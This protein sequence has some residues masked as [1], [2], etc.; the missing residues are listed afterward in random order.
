MKIIHLITAFQLGGAEKVAFDIVNKLNKDYEIEL[1]AIFKNDDDFSKEFKKNL[2]KNKI[3]WRELALTTKNSKF[4]YL[5]LFYSSLALLFYMPKNKIKIIHSHTDLPDFVLAIMLNF[6]K[7]IKNKKLN[8]LRTIHNTELWPTHFTIGKF[9]ESSFEND[10][11]VFI[12]KDVEKAYRL[13][14]KKYNLQE[15]PNT[16]FISNGVDFEKYNDEVNAE[17]LKTLNITLDKNKINLLFV[18]RLVEQKGFDL[19]IDLFNLLDEKD[20]N[21]F[22]IYAFGSGELEKLVTEKMPIDIYKPITNIHEIYKCFDYL[23][24]PSRFE[25]LGL[26]SLEASASRLPVIASYSCGLKETLPDNWELFF[27]NESV[28]DLKK[29][30]LDI[31]NNNYDRYYLSKKSNI[32]VK[33]NFDLKSTIEKYHQLYR[34]ME[35]L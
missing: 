18:G 20:K 10:H 12:S 3:R 9:V 16:Y 31:L 4:K 19:I 22:H 26:V 28:E 21:R 33:E 5:S 17:I 29:L 6:Y 35:E 14:R 2:E 8:I 24:M 7:F 32:F 23:I 11:V 30:L 15:S 13:L 34:K 1:I 27:K 25:G